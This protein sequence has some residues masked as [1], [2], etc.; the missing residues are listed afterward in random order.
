MRN[1]TIFSIIFNC[2]LFPCIPLLVFRNSQE[3]RELLCEENNSVSPDYCYSTPEFGLWVL[4]GVSAFFVVVYVV[5]TAC[6]RK[7]IGKLMDVYNVS[8]EPIFKVKRIASIPIGFMVLGAATMGGLYVLMLYSFGIG[9]VVK[10]DQNDVPGGKVNKLE[11][12]NSDRLVLGYIIFMCY[13]WLG[14]MVAVCEFVVGGVVAAWHFTKEKSTIY[15]P[16]STSFKYCFRY[17]LGSIIRGSFYNL[18]LKPPQYFL[19]PL[20]T[21]LFRTKTSKFSNFLACFCY[22]FLLLHNHFFKYPSSSAYIILSIFGK[23]YSISSRQSYYLKKRNQKRTEDF[24]FTTWIGMIHMKFSIILPGFISIYSFLLLNDDSIFGFSSKNLTS[25]L[26]P[27]VFSVIFCI[28]IAQVACSSFYAAAEAM[29]LCVAA[30]EEMFTADQRFVKDQVQEVFDNSYSETRK[31][32]FLGIETQ[33]PGRSNRM[34][35]NLIEFDSSFNAKV[36]P[37]PM[38]SGD[39]SYL[40]VSDYQ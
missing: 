36:S 12:R 19:H 8:T 23:P 26:A 32:E 13:W 40:H 2:I 17:H 35:V 20:N 33:R 5:F 30:D 25:F 1:F 11:F 14:F 38:K 9:D 7:R 22:P 28:F 21:Y 4:T 15:H 39:R 34:P 3:I 16:V 31:A 6:Y 37:I 24:L 18:F 27:A 29:A 10:Y